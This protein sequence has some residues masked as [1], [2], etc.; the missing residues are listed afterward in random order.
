MTP[1]F[2][3]TADALIAT[4]KQRNTTLRVAQDLIDQQLLR[5]CY[6]EYAHQPQWCSPNGYAVGDSRQ[7]SGV[8]TLRRIMDV[9]K[10]LHDVAAYRDSKQPKAAA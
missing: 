8:G 9:E 7:Q 6:R 3:R 1:L 10:F 5:D 2:Q 4:A